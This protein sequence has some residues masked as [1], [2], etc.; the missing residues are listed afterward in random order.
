MGK[1]DSRSDEGIF[2][3]Y[4]STTKAYRVY[5]K[6]IMKV[7]KTMNVVIDESLDSS[8]EKGIEEFPK[9]ILH[10][11]PKEVQEIVEQEPASLSTPSTPSVVEDSTDIPTSPDSKSHKEKG[12]SSRIKLNH[13]L[14]VIVGNM[15]ELTLRKGVVDKCVANFVSYSCYL[16]QVEP[17]KVEETFQD[18][19]WVKAMHDELLQ[20][21]RN[22]VWTLVPRPEGEHIISTKW[23]FRNKTDEEGNVI[24]NKARLVAQGYSQM[25]AVDYDETFALVDCMESIRILLALAC[26]LKFKLYQMDVKTAFLNGLLKEDVYVA[27]PKGFID[28]HFPDHV[29]YLKKALYG[30]KQALELGMIGSHNTW[31]HMGSQKEKLIRLSSSKRKMAS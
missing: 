28:P 26:Q 16:S 20:F 24:C 15:N 6:R 1:F 9:E 18:E 11:E 13:P 7:M 17:T 19:S 25:E 4:S 30:L 31:C 3:G 29:L 23:I 10:P 2:L 14:E 21:Q 5:N 27:Q 12:P 22:D 8:S